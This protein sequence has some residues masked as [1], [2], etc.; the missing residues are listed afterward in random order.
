MKINFIKGNIAE[1][2]ADAIVLP[3][4]TMLKEGSGASAAIFEAAGR[5][6]LTKA[7]DKIGSCELGGAVPT[8]AYGLNAKFILH[9]VVPKW[10][11]GQHQEYELLSAAYLE[12]LTLADIMD[13]KTIAFPLLASGNNGFDLTVALEIA[14]KS[15]MAFS[16]NTLEDVS[17][18]I[19]GAKAKSVVRGA[20]Y[21]VLPFRDEKL[22]K[23]A[24]QKELVKN[25]ISDGKDVAQEILEDE[26]NRAFEYLKERKNR[27]IILKKGKDIVEIVLKFVKK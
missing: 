25:K 15:I 4:N 27:E 7:C 13:C 2:T 6:K 24:D 11:D 26:I 16:A 18:I 5:R 19:F 1:V 8:L 14:V 21:E 3:A 20:G 22:I 9:T 17:I 10:T 12:T 23:K